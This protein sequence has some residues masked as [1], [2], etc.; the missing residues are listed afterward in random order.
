MRN[1]IDIAAKRGWTVPEVYKAI[2]TWRALYA[3][4]P[5]STLTLN[6]YFDMMQA[7]G[8]R[9]SMIGLHHGKYS[10]ARFNDEGPY[11]LDNCRFIPIQDN[12]SERREGYQQKPAFKKLMSELALKRSRYVCVHCQK[13]SSPGMHARWHGDNCKFKFTT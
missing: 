2:N 4:Q 11:N 3:R 5:K 13:D 1:R 10:L 7:S 6:E 9:P 12:V 8:L